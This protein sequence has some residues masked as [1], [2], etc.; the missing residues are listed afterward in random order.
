MKKLTNE[1]VLIVSEKIKDF[2]VGISS[3]LKVGKL[4]EFGKLK[5]ELSDSA[6]IIRETI[7]NQ[8][9]EKFKKL[10]EIRDEKIKKIREKNPILEK[11][12]DWTGLELLLKKEWPEFD[13]FVEIANEENEKAN[14]LLSEQCS[15]F[16][17]KF[18]L[19]EDDFTDTENKE[20]NKIIAENID[21]VMM[22]SSDDNGQPP[23]PPVKG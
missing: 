11:R 12:K 5:N 17:S 21:I 10:S 23:L 14:V 9:S 3:I 22:L 13:Y 16:S 19:S 2:I 7:Q 18:T 15:I 20:A 6:K 4:L 1:E 8:Q